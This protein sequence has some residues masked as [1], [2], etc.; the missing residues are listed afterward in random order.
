MRV[1]VKLVVVDDVIVP[2]HCVLVIEGIN[3]KLNV[4]F[5]AVNADC[6]EIT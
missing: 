2:L 6:Y 4:P 5:D 3:V 1:A